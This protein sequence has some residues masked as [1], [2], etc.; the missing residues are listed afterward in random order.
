MPLS[1]NS[2]GQWAIE[3]Y[4]FFPSDSIEFLDPEKTIKNPIWAPFDCGDLGVH[5]FAFTMHVKAEFAYVPGQYFSFL[6]DDDIWVFINDTLVI[7]I[8]VNTGAVD[9]DSLHLTP[10]KTYPFEIFYAE[11]HT[12]GSNYV[13]RTSIDLRT[14]RTYYPIEV[15]T[16][17]STTQYVVSQ[18]VKGSGLSCDFSSSTQSDTL[19]APS[20]YFLS[21]PMFPDGPKTLKAG[22]N[23]GG[24]TIDADLAGFTIDTMA[25]IRERSLAP[26]KYTLR[27]EHAM[28]A[29][30]S[31]SV[32]FLVS[33]YPLPTIVFTDSLWNQIDPDTV[34]LGEWAMVPYPVHIEARYV[35]IKC[36]DCTDELRFTTSDSLVFL[37]A[38]KKPIT[39]ML[40]DSG[41]ATFWVMAVRTVDSAQFLASGPKIANTLVWRHI[42]LKE[43]PVPIQRSAAMYDNNG[44]GVGDSLVIAYS[45][46]L[47]GKDVLDSL[48]WSFGDSLLHRQDSLSLASLV[49]AD[50]TIV[51]KGDNL[52]GFPFTGNTDGKPYGGAVVTSFTYTPTDGADAGK[53]LPAHITGV[54][55]DRIGPV[56]LAA[57]IGAGKTVDTLYVTI[58]E[59]MPADSVK[60]GELFE[61]RMI[62]DGVDRFADVRLLGSSKQEESTRFTLLYSNTGKAVPSVGDSIRLVPGKGY[63]VSGNFAHLA[64]PLVR[65]IGRPTQRFAE[66]YDRNGDGIGDSLIITYSRPLLGTD[67]PDSLLWRFGD[68][69]FHNQD[70]LALASRIVNS[71]SIV[72][73]GDSLVGFRFTGNTDG[74]PYLGEVVSSFTYTATDSANAGKRLPSKIYGPI[75]DKIGPVILTAEVGTGKSVDTLF[76]DLSE[77]MPADSV[78]VKDLFA[79]QILRAGVERSAEAQLFSGSRR[80]KGARYFLLY[81]NSIDIIPSVGDSIR[82]V[83][84]KGYDVSGNFA[85]S[86]NRLVRIVGRQRA[87][88]ETLGLVSFT[89]ANAPSVDAP[90]VRVVRATLGQTIEDLVAQEGVPGHLIQ[91]DLSNIVL[92]SQV[93]LDPSTVKLNYETWYHT[94]IG[95]YV[96]NTK[97]SVACS[98]SIFHG[99]C[100]KFPGN[101]FIGWNLRAKTGRL[102]ST[103]PYISE[104]GFQVYNGT[105]KIISK[106][107]KQVWGIRREK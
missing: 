30:L 90:T 19:K 48:R 56:V 70:S 81:N 33:T 61:I 67:A 29:T 87:T 71:T 26:G 16:T 38:N 86:D 5:N 98:D 93:E 84:G 73:T 39:G 106:K 99:D 20:N 49:V 42:Q 11:R 89:A 6:G 91:F 60:I 97:G 46:T 17:N 27:F 105:E 2:D 3:S 68:S 85:H 65:I 69:L 7:D 54:I 96:N 36:P 35:G 37:D 83:P 88:I 41:R 34:T 28:D 25:I 40:L 1:L 62:R 10:G 76:I 4:S 78:D 14:T 21:G 15:K 18:I 77:S 72:L 59:S 75:E 66:M 100:T 103:G 57:E 82:L 74:T 24:V 31:Y 23:Y 50:T 102:V 53:R 94:N 9:L 12:C 22:L 58:S 45:K 8:A 92:N 52:V 55:A 63:D 95:A 80:G 107:S 47:R 44:D 51:L 13:M 43:P 64:N 79:L 101:I 104:L 32:Q